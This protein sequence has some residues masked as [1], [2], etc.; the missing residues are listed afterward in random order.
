MKYKKGMNL[1]VGL[2]LTAVLALSPINGFASNDNSA[3]N[4]SNAVASTQQTNTVSGIVRDNTGEPLIG[5]S[6]VLKSNQ[7]VGTVTNMD[8]HYSISVPS[9]ST[10]VFSYVGYKSQTVKVNGGSLNIT[11]QED[12]SNLEEVVVVGYGTMKKSDLTGTTSNIK[13]DAI[14]ANVTGNALEALQGKAA[15][16]AVFNDNNPGASP[17]IRIRGSSSI[18]ASNEPL[19]VVDGFPLMD[20]DIS[21]I[22]PADIESMEILKDASATAIYGSRGANGV[23]M[24]TTKTGKVGTKNLSFN[25]S[26]GM[27]MPG[28]KLDIVSGQDFIDFINAEYTNYNGD[29]SKSPFANGTSWCMNPKADTDWEDLLLNDHAWLQNYNVSLDGSSNGTSYMLSGGYY[30]QEGLTPTAGFEKFSFHTNLRH[31]FNSWLTLGGSAQYTYARRNSETMAVSNVARYGWPTDSPWD[32]DGN[33]VVPTNPYVSDA[34]NPMI[35]YDEHISRTNTVRAIINAFAEAKILPELTYRISIGQDVRINRGYG[36]N[37]SNLVGNMA[38]GT[39]NGSHSWNKGRSKLMENMLTYAKNWNDIHRFTAT[40][41]YS[42]QDYDYQSTGVSGSG[43]TV[44]QLEAWDIQNAARDT[45]NPSSDRYSN[46]LISY[47]G[48][49]TYA[50]MDKYLLTATARWD[51]SSRFGADKK[52]GFFPSVGLAWRASEEAFLK[53][54]KVISDLK[55]RASFGVTGNQ[56]IGNYKSLAQLEASGNYVYDNKELVGYAQTKLANPDLQWERTNQ[57]NFGF[58]LGLWNRF[59]VNFDYYIRDTNKLLYEVPLPRETGFSNLLSNVGSTQNK[60]WELTIGGNIFKNKDWFVD[61]SVNL[62]Y[63]KNKIKSLY[64]ISGVETKEIILRQDGTGMD[65]RLV[66]G[67]PVDGLYARKSLGIIKTQEQLDWYKQYVPNTAQNA[68]LGDEMYED[69]PDENGDCNGSIGYEDYIC[70]GSV[71]PKYFYG[72]NLSAGYKAFSVNIYGQGGL[73][74]ASIAGAEANNNNGTEWALSFSDNG[75]YLLWGENN[76]QERMYFPSTYAYERMWSPSNP[77]GDFPRPGSRGTYLS[78]RT[79]GDWTYFI[80]KNIQ[81]NYDFSKLLKVKTI[82]GLKVNLNFQNFVTFA[83]HRGYNPVNG[84]ISNPW[85]KSVILGVDLK[86]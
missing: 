82:K 3:D 61:A 43:F 5:V 64:N 83:N 80:L 27:Q 46:R 85:A 77:D 12:R 47:T 62:T 4:L 26:V 21:D 37:T 23:V 41:V 16:V 55:L 42:W 44:D 35:D 67:K 57:W 10:L 76:I 17:A 29:A 28:R 63:N 70:I 73:K 9:G 66:V 38:K 58:D 22:N 15:G 71:Q 11:L 24:I 13:T 8:G 39:G 6:V 56:E 69:Q 60:G 1:F 40:A 75:S 65:R 25:S 52:W 53:D 51:G 86:F 50:Y 20:G 36:Y 72:L 32:A 33:L 18:N 45:W 79:N 31:Q 74:Y 68:S 30:N 7:R 2:S 49:I 34:W 48:R 14:M 59:T 19:Y 81:F 84:D 54:N 78:D